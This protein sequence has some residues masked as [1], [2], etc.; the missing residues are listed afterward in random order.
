MELRVVTYSIK[1]YKL[2]EILCS[3]IRETN[4]NCSVIHVGSFKDAANNFKV[5]AF[6]SL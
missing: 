6:L 1:G 4:A 5:S 3:S 2:I